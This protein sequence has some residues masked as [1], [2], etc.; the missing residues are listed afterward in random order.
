MN[1]QVY[2]CRNCKRVFIPTKIDQNIV[3]S[4]LTDS[5]PKA[6]IKAEKGRKGVRG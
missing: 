1:H 2:K 5:L 6:I 3:A 4:L